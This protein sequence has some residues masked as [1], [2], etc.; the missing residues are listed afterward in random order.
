V[1]PAERA[2]EVESVI[3]RAVDQF[4]IGWRLVGGIAHALYRL[5]HA[6][7]KTKKPAHIQVS[8]SIFR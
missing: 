3:D 6:G 1:V 5:W 8:G 4:L 2:F 7:I